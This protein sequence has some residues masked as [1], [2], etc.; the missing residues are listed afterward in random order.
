MAAF[1]TRSGS[2]RNRGGSAGF[3]F[4]LYALVSIVIMVLD[5]RLDWLERVRFALQTVTYPVEVVLNSPVTGWHWLEREFASRHALEGENRRLRAR[6]HELEMR[7]LRVDALGAQNAALIG[8]KHALPPVAERWLPADIVNIELG[9]LRQRILVDRGERNGV[10]RNQA[11][12]DDYGVVGQ[13]IHVGP[14]SA[15]VQLITDPDHDLPVQNVRT[16]FRTIAVGTGDP[17]ALALPYLP[18]NADIRVGD[19][20]VTAGLGGVFPSGYPVGRVTEVHPSAAQP[21]ARVRVAPFAHLATDREVM[22][23]WFRQGNPASPLKL[24][25]GQLTSGNPAVQPLPAPKPK[26]GPAACTPAPATQKPGARQPG[27]APAQPKAASPRT[28]Q[29]QP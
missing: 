26:T 11:V 6:L 10:F 4:S 5:Q 2:P 23:L 19:V 13:T 12:L 28:G 8:L 16:G 24:R 21:L 25:G 20:L 14:W 29:S 3:R 7:T 22:L 1:G 9:G 15:E 18:A 17:D 27:S